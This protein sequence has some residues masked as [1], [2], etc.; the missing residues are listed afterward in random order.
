MTYDWQFDAACVGVD[1]R[2]FHPQIRTGRKPPE[3]VPRPPQVAVAKRICAS[4]SV[5]AECLDAGKG[6]PGIWGGLEEH[7]RKPQGLKTDSTRWQPVGVRVAIDNA[8][9]N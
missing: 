2:I 4:C 5:T 9:K 3:K 7:E 6:A 1:P 8:L